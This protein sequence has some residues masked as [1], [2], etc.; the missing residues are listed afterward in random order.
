[1]IIVSQVWLPRSPPFYLNNYGNSR[2][3]T[4]IWVFKLELQLRISAFERLKPMR[5]RLRLTCFTSYFVYTKHTVFCKCRERWE[6][7]A[8]CQIVVRPRWISRKKNLIK[9]TKRDVTKFPRS[10]V[11]PNQNWHHI[12]LRWK[13]TFFEFFFRIWEC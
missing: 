1:M 8:S 9:I 4:R 10:I 13:L 3:K 12:L 6:M 7:R 2:L 11:I 5:Q